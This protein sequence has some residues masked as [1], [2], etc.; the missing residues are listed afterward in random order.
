MNAR[1]HAINVQTRLYAQRAG[2]VVGVFNPRT[3]K[4]ICR[5]CGLKIAAEIRP[6]VPECA[7]SRQK[8]SVS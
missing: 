7:K 6:N 4:A 8:I 1:Q 5:R 2:H 3:R